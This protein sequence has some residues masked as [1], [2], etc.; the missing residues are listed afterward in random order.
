VSLHFVAV[1][2]SSGEDTQDTEVTSNLI[3]QDDLRRHSKL[4]V[5]VSTSLNNSQ[6]Y[7]YQDIIKDAKTS[8]VNVLVPE[9]GVNNEIVFDSE[10][11]PK[12]RETLENPNLTEYY[13]FEEKVVRVCII[14]WLI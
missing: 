10:K 9:S 6:P 5:N 4:N 12:R 7:R 2:L 3:A 8:N 14:V 11:F 1:E 13:N